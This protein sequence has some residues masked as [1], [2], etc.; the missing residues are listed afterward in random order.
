M[1]RRSERRHKLRKKRRREHRA[2]NRQYPEYE[3][4]GTVSGRF[5]STPE[6]LP[7]GDVLPVSRHGACEA[8]VDV[9]RERFLKAYQCYRCG[10]RVHDDTPDGHMV[11]CDHK[12]HRPPP[13]PNKVWS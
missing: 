10:A 7:G 5:S 6:P 3:L 2:L 11:P 1:S 12:E 4:V 9:V 8:D 13:V